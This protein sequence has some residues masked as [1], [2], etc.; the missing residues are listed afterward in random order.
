MSWKEIDKSH[1]VSEGWGSLVEGKTVT[2]LR[3]PFKKNK[4]K[5]AFPKLYSGHYSESA[6]EEVPQLKIELLRVFLKPY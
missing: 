2:K 5:Q 4:I 1:C 6:M 3:R